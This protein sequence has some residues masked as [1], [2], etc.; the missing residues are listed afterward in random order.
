MKYFLLSFVFIFSIILARAQNSQ[1]NNLPSGTYETVV[2]NN[3]NKWER[4]D[5]ILIDNNK[6][7]VS[8]SSEVGDYRFSVTAQRIFFTSGPLKSVYAKTSLNKDTPTIILP[9]S[10]NEQLGLKLPSEVYGYYR[11]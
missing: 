2:K 5:I 10:E 4:G 1:V 9:V 7:R 8:S 6:Y 11:K 3:Q